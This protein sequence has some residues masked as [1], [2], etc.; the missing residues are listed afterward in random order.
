MYIDRWLNNFWGV[1]IHWLHLSGLDWRR[2]LHQLTSPST[3]NLSH[4]IQ[5]HR[6]NHGGGVRLIVCA[7]VRIWDYVWGWNTS[8]NRHI[9]LNKMHANENV[10]LLINYS[11]L[12]ILTTELVLDKLCWQVTSASILF[13]QVF[14]QHITNNSMR[15]RPSSD[16]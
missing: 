5:V 13:K 1:K 3:L 14:K 4:H 10:K 8:S 6:G 16:N 2:K 7:C 11:R 9:S 15:S 12:H